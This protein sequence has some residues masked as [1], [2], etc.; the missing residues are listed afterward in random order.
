MLNMSLV[1]QCGLKQKGKT[2]LNEL[3]TVWN[4]KHL[5]MNS[6]VQSFLGLSTVNL[7]LDLMLADNLLP[8]HNG[9]IFNL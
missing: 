4:V 9:V 7:P 3:V 8:I 2:N 5:S 1:L 6:N